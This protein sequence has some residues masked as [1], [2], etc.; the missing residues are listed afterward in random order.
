M[1]TKKQLEQEGWGFF[2]DENGYMI[3]V[4]TTGITTKVTA[5]DLKTLL[6]HIPTVKKILNE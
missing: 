2:K 6:K 3:A 1:E 5:K 4:K